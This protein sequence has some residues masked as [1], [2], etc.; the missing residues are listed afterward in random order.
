MG[1]AQTFDEVVLRGDPAS[2]R[3]LAFYL[4]EGALRAVFGL[5]RSGDPEAPDADG[6]LKACV[7][8]IREAARVDPARLA[9]E[10]QDLRR[11]AIA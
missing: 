4:R 2:R 7:P 9:D 10:S 6:E 11:V 1:F 3:F 5:D 8:L